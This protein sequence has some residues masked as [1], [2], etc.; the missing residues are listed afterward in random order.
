HLVRIDA[1][2][3]LGEFPVTQAQF[4]AVMG[5]NPSRFKGDSDRPVE[6]VSWLMAQEFCLRMSKTTGRRVRLPSE[7]EWEYACRA[8]TT[9]KY[10][11]GQ[12]ATAEHLNCKTGDPLAVSLAED[13]EDKDDAVIT[14]VRGRF[15]PNAWG[16]YDML[17]NVQEWCEDEW[18][19][20]YVGAPTD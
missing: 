4:A 5:C 12:E 16:F 13:P 9:F 18:H 3:Y 8:G 7:A 20:N 19:D 2:F 15:P 14:N 1:P 6:N 11:W 17:G 10:H